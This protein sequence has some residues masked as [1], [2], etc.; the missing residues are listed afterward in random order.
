[1]TPDLPI[2][3]TEPDP[4]DAFD[5]LRNL[6]SLWVMRAHALGEE[7]LRLRELPHPTT[8]DPTP[9]ATARALAGNAAEAAELAR[10]L[11]AVA[12]LY[13]QPVTT[14][15]LAEGGTFLATGP[16]HQVLKQVEQVRQG[17]QELM[18]KDRAEAGKDT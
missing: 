13:D 11:A 5:H 4:P 14:F 9:M 17:A 3:V 18:R 16:G 10:T 7:V 6:A 12:E 8:D 1:M 15:E 2:D